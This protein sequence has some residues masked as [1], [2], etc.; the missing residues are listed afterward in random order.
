MLNKIIQ[1]VTL[2]YRIQNYK[3]RKSASATDHRTE[4][5]AVI[6]EALSMKDSI[7]LRISSSPRSSAI[8]MAFSSAEYEIIIKI[9]IKTNTCYT[10]QS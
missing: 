8:I 10:R 3:H 7:A 6:N 4:A 1:N 5:A 2:V 9:K